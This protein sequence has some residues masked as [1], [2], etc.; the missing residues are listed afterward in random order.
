MKKEEI[1]CDTETN[2]SLDL[3]EDYEAEKNNEPINALMEHDQNNNLIGKNPLKIDTKKLIEAGH[4]PRPISK[5]I[6]KKCIDCCGG[7]VGEVAKCV[8]ITCPLWVYRMGKNPFLSEKR[9]ESNN[10]K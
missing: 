8:C 4:V 10:L 5:I 7:Q 3:F 1:C 2:P 6:R 9:K